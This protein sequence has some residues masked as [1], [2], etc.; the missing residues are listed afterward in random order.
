MPRTRIQRRS[1]PAPLKEN[2]VINPGKGLNTFVSENIIDDQEA[3][4]L[5]NV[6][7]I[8][9]GAVRK[10][11]GY[12]QAGDALSNNPRGIGVFNR[13]SGNILLT[14]DGTALKYLNGSTWTT[15]SGE[16]FDSSAQ[17][18]FLQAGDDLYIFD[19]VN[20]VAKLTSAL[21]LARNGKSP[22]AK[23]G[24]LYGSYV[25]IA[26]VDGQQDRVYQSIQMT[27]SQDPDDWTDPEDDTSSHP[28][29]SDFTGTNGDTFYFDIGKGD[30]DK[31]TGFAK[32]SDVL[33]VFKE[34]SIHQVVLDSSGVPTITAISSSIGCV[35]H[36]SIENV[37]NDVFFLSRDG[38]YVLGNE[39]NFFDVVRTNE[40]SARIKEDVETVTEA[41]YNKVNAIYFDNKYICGI[42]V[43]GSTVN[44]VFVYDR[45]FLAWSKWTNVSSNSWGTLINSSG[46]E[47]LYFA[48][49]GDTKVHMMT[50]GTYNDNG[51]AISAQWTSKAFDL[52]RFDLQKRWLFM[53]VLFRQI[54]G[55]VAIYV[56]TDNDQLSAQ[57]T[58]RATTQGGM[59]YLQL[60]YG[61]LGD[62]GETATGDSSTTSNVPYRIVINES[63]RT[64]KVKFENNNLNENFVF[65]GMAHYYYEF[66]PFK[67]DSQF[68]LTP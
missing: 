57:T 48:D 68:K 11:D 16:T 60:G 7:F 6:Q 1:K 51:S 19:G 38:F 21:S 10:R 45:R 29:A 50:P 52:N 8:E 12:T 32:F 25:F 53:D 59:G 27:Q 35:S 44:T 61:P 15:I 63:S 36:K 56:Y 22:K 54:Q 37:E 47:E 9:S 66:S 46:E 33:I 64:L 55:S 18:E 43:G 58:I 67:F 34:R 31:I 17:I 41:N 13:S 40:L 39:P 42:P 62:D 5:E 30:G 24:I 2:R 26:G 4:S 49:D 14:V 3:T 23:F 65:L 28:G 20:S